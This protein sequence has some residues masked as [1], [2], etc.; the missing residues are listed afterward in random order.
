MK[1]RQGLS[2]GN[3][4]SLKIFIR[5]EHQVGFVYVTANNKKIWSGS[6]TD[7]ER[8]LKAVLMEE[9]KDIS[10][11]ALSLF[12]FMY[13]HFFFENIKNLKHVMKDGN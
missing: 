10:P 5:F 2:I 4:N 9:A 12:N 8:D 6:D 11:R 13:S 1:N 7:L 3:F